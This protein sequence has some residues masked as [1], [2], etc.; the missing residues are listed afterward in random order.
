[1]TGNPAD[2][3]GR[4]ALAIMAAGLDGDDLGA[5]VVVAAANTH[6]VIVA[7]VAMLC[8]ELAAQGINPREWVSQ[9]QARIAGG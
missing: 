5:G 8:E 3:R 6:G 7:F 2:I 1:M 4:H 9:E